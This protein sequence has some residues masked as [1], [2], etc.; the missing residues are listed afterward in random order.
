[1]DEAVVQWVFLKSSAMLADALGFELKRCLGSELT[2]TAGRLDLLYETI[3][4]ELL[5]IELETTIPNEA[6]VHHCT[7][8]LERYLALDER[9]PAPVYFILLYAADGTP[10][11]IARRL[12]RWAEEKG[13]LIRTYT[14]ERIEA[15]LTE[16]IDRIR[17]NSGKRIAGAVALGVSSLGWLNKLTGQF[18]ATDEDGRVRDDAA[19]IAAIDWAEIKSR[20]GSATSFYVIKRL[21][22]DFELVRRG[23]EEGDDDAPV[24]EMRLTE[25]GAAF[26][27]AATAMVVRDALGESLDYEGLSTGQRRLLLQSLLS[28]NITKC[29]ANLLYFLRLVHFY[30][31][32]RIPRASTRLRPEEQRFFNSI[33]STSYGERTLRDLVHLSCTHCAELGLVTRLA[34]P[35]G[36]YERVL[37]TSLGARVLGYFELLL[38]LHREQYQIPLQI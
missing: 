20:F 22:E 37:L 7:D 16:L 36:R 34:E 25:R 15:R 31:G 19:P 6:K 10:S 28:G 9:F 23:R 12:A 2:T 11:S 27:D 8:Q 33:L 30:G 32:D 4:G 24:D 13:V 1:M 5:V 21:A 38:H 17:T 3:A 29:K 35:S 18:Y 14:R 26:R